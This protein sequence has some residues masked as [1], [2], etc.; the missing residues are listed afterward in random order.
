MPFNYHNAKEFFYKKLG[1]DLEGQGRME[2]AYYHTAEF[3]Y[4]E[5]CKDNDAAKDAAL[6]QCRTLL[7][8]ST[9]DIHSA[10]EDILR[11]DA[12]IS[13]LVLQN[14]DLIVEVTQLRAAIEAMR[15]AGGSVEFQARF[16]DAKQLIKKD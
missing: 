2:S 5:G 6:D 15:V 14:S 3:I 10:N 11:K 4:N 7:R 9:S 8:L 13:S 1:S 16:D 12:E